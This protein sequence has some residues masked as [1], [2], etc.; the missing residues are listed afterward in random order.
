[1]CRVVSCA[2]SSGTV[3]CICTYALQGLHNKCV[4]IGFWSPSHRTEMVRW[5]DALNP[6]DTDQSGNTTYELWGKR[7]VFIHMRIVTCS[8]ERTYSHAC[9]HTHTHTTHTHT[10]FTECLVYLVNM[11]LV[12]F[13]S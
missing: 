7:T 1:M 8:D 11:T 12:P 9:A 2:L 13:C 6:P 4:H 3:Q 5:I 10:R